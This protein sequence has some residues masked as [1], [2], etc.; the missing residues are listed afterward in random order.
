MSG[1]AKDQKLGHER[2]KKHLKLSLG[3]RLASCMQQERTHMLCNPDVSY[4]QFQFFC[5]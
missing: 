4:Q 5:L 3:I 2:N 1:D